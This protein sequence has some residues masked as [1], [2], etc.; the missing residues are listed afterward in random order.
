ME[1]TEQHTLPTHKA[2]NQKVELF[3]L[4]PVQIKV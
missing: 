3:L 1:A 4:D 2:Q